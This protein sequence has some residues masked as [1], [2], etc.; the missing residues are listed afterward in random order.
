MLCFAGVVVARKHGRSGRYE[1]G[2]TR[3]AGRGG[4]K[5][6]RDDRCVCHDGAR[7]SGWMSCTYGTGR[8]LSRGR[9]ALCVCT[10]CAHVFRVS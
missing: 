10:L 8:V 4:V 1:Q 2:T 3:R 9:D 5:T 7:A 6:E